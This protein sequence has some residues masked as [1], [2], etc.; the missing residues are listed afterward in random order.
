MEGSSD[1]SNPYALS[2]TVIGNSM[3]GK[4]NFHNIRIFAT[5]DENEQG[6]R[7]IKSNLIR[8]I[9]KED[10][11]IH[12]DKKMDFFYMKDLVSVVGHFIEKNNPPKRFDCTYERTKNLSEIA[13]IINNLGS[14]KVNV[15]RDLRRQEDYS[16]NFSDL[17]LRYI[18]L[19]QG[20]KNTYKAIICGQ[21]N[22]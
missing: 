20:I 22:I 7:F 17:G 10:M 19:R 15:P 2:K 1:T 16:G 5:F 11:I 14:Y 4:D 9:N 6:D 3:T 12:H 18:G 13:D 8:Y 21:K